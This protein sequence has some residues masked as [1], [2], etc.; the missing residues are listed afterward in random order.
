LEK[1]SSSVQ[2]LV[3]AIMRGKAIIYLEAEDFLLLAQCLVPHDTPDI[4]ANYRNRPLPATF[5]SLGKIALIVTQNVDIPTT[6]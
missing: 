5:S 3:R 6:D 4:P 1:L 2:A